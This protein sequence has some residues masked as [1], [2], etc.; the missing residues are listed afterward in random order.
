MAQAKSKTTKSPVIAIPS[1]ADEKVRLGKVAVIAGVGLA[2]GIIW[3][4]LVGM[5]LTPTPPSDASSSVLAGNPSASA[6]VTVVGE[7]PPAAPPKAAASASNEPEPSVKP[8][9]VTLAQVVSCR[10]K[11]A[12]RETRCDTP[13]IDTAVQSPLQSLVAC[14]AA[15]GVRGVLSLG[16]DA[17]FETNRL[18]HFTV[19]KSTTMPSSTAK[20]LLRCAEKELGRVSLEGVTHSKSSY[21]IFYK[22]E[23]SENPA[24]SA[25][26]STE[27][28]T[29]S[30]AASTEMIAASGRVT[31]TWDAALVRAKPKDGEIL[32]RVLGGT[33]LTVTG[34]QGEWY[35]V[36]YD[37]K[38]SEGWV[39]KSAIG[40]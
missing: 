36:K 22:I 6:S 39:Y 10:D 34:R 2:A 24:D 13:G 7:P 12:E 15:A 11:N 29:G 1:G 32:A 17:D 26:T 4:R 23:F 14:D 21:R 8:P 27:P 20:Q 3:P 38:G 40:L 31:V 35:R 33:R 18:D 25:G 9:K 5:Q 28:A 30:P 19:G 16:F 37:A